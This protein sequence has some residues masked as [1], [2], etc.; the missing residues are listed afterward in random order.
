MSALDALSYLPV[1]PF[2]AILALLVYYLLKRAA[3]KRAR[4]RG[5]RRPGFC[6]SSAAFSVVF[7]FGVSFIRPSLA[8]VTEAIQY[9]ESVEDD[10]GDPES[11]EKHLHRQLRKIRRGEAID[12]LV[13]DLSVRPVSGKRERSG[14]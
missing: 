13:M 1:L 3:W 10:D 8:H 6:P 14:A 9:E 7:L 4:Y 12:R 2:A 11:P 5:K